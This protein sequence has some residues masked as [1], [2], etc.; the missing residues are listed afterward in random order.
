MSTFGSFEEFWAALGRLYDQQLKHDQ[1]IAQNAAQIAQISQQMQATDARFDRL[2]SIVETLA[3][4][5][6]K[7]ADQIASHERRLDRLE[8]TA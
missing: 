3:D 6:D 8:G 5:I 1:Q 4:K 7:Q 2:I